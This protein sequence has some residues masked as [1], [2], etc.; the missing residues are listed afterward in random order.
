MMGGVVLK[1]AT[2]LCLMFYIAPNKAWETRTSPKTAKP[3]QNLTRRALLPMIFLA[4]LLPS[5]T[6]QALDSNI[7]EEQTKISL[8]Q[9]DGEDA[10]RPFVSAAYS[11]K[12]LTNSIVAS[13]DTNISPAE[14]YETIKR[15]KN[16]GLNG[17]G[18]TSARALDVGAGAG[19]STQVIF[20]ELGYSNIDA[21]DWSGDAWRINVEDGGYCPPS[22]HFYEL[23]DERFMEKWKKE[24]LEKYD[25]I[26]FNFAVNRDKALCFSK[27]LLKEE[28]LLLAPINTQPDYWLKQTYQLMDVDGKVVWS[29]GDVG[30]WSVQFQPD[31]TQDTCQGVWCSPFNGFQKLRR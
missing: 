16:G 3:P 17:S 27:N 30:A 9:Q 19:V 24:K 8:Q 14:V 29:A 28:G 6:A 15:L 26:A 2:L 21:L 22:V 18:S 1:C 25:I 12:E 10:S 4:P 5:T 7:G 23:D 11:R 31:V 20:Q 13:R